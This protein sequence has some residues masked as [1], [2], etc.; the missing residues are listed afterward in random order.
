[1]SK[2]ILKIFWK[3]TR[4][5]TLVLSAM[6]FCMGLCM[7]LLGLRVYQSVFGSF[8]AQLE[9]SDFVVLSKDVAF[10]N[11]LLNSKS[12]LEPAEVEA[13]QKQP[14]VQKLGFFTPNHYKVW[15]K[16]TA[17]SGLAFATELF[18][19]SVPD[20]FVDNRPSSFRWDDPTDPVPIMVSEDFINLYNYGYAVSSGLPQV[21]KGTV[22]L[23]PLEIELS[24]P[25]GKR[26]FTGKIVGYSERISSVL[27]PLDFM[28]WANKNI[29]QFSGT[30]K[31]ARLIVKTNKKY[32][33]GMDSYLDA[34]GLLVN[35]DKLGTAKLSAWGKIVVDIL[36]LLGIGFVI[37]SFVIVLLNFS[38]II[39]E[40]KAEIT[41]LLQLGYDVLAIAKHLLFYLGMY[42]GI[43]YGIAALLYYICYAYLS[44]VLIAR[45]LV[46]TE[47]DVYST[48]VLL[49]GSFL[50]LNVLGYLFIVYNVR[51]RNL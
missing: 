34:N 37:F 44:K 29:G 25:G 11:T 5:P 26:V 3:V 6:G 14:F 45:G 33:G 4:I 23:I 51:R 16:V 27:V 48:P 42:M 36:V 28:H 10:L 50:V 13:L 1:M 15:A 12:V 47:T 7:V 8:S 38:L 20:E 22:A 19:E 24:G 41:L 40:A 31:P 43:V 49:L 30:D 17:G 35:S 32:A 39:T 9:Q 18:F 46:S 2:M 21:S